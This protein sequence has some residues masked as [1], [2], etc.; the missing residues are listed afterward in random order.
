MSQLWDTDVLVNAVI[1]EIKVNL[2]EVSAWQKGTFLSLDVNPKDAIKIFC[3]DVPLF[4]GVMGRHGDHVVVRV[5]GKAEK[6]G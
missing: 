2:S 5:E 1:R 3:G 6:D 4:E